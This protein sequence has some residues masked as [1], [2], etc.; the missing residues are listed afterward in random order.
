MEAAF[1]RIFNLSWSAGWMIL[2]VLVSR[3]MLKKAPRWVT[4][5]LWGLVGLRLVM[6]FSLRS[7]LSLIPSAEVFDSSIDYHWSMSIRSGIPALDSVINPL[8]GSIPAWDPWEG[9]SAKRILLR[10]FSILWVAGAALLVLHGLIGMLR[11]RKKVSEAVPYREN[12]L[13]CDRV[14]SPF[15]LGVFRPRIYLPSDLGE[16]ETELVLA[17]EFAH[18]RRRDHLWKPLGYLILALHWFNPLV[19]IAYVLLCRDIEAACDEKVVSGME[20]A[21]KKAYANALVSCSLPRRLVLACPLAFGE[22]GVKKRVK[23]VLSYK[24]PAAWLLAVGLTACAVL[25]VCFLTV[26]RSDYGAD[27]EGVEI[28]YGAS[29]LYSMEDREAAVRVILAE[30]RSWTGFDLHS[31]RYTSDECG[32][33]ENLSWLNQIAPVPVSKN[34]FTQCIRFESDFH[35]T[36]QFSRE[37]FG[38][39]MPDYEYRDWQW[40]LGRV[41]GGKWYLVTWGY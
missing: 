13:L 19:W 34:G 17:H 24:K 29:S 8:L 25:A 16:R 4:V 21:D 32:S 18:L 27:F 6:P 12:V 23:G 15:I 31:V 33:A 26:P 5:L 38:G 3:L 30:F 10:F 11:L 2:A 37:E 14:N 40:W 39:F 22:V 1:T 36:P 41:D 35:T 20:L 9:V 28:D 7:A